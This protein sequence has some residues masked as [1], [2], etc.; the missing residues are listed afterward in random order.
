M[1]QPPQWCMHS[2]RRGIITGCCRRAQQAGVITSQANSSFV[3]NLRHMGFFFKMFD[4]NVVSLYTIII[5]IRS[6][7][8]QFPTVSKWC[9]QC[10]VQH[11]KSQKKK[12]EPTRPCCPQDRAVPHQR[13]NRNI[14]TNILIK[15]TPNECIQNQAIKIQISG[16]K[17]QN[18]PTPV[19]PLQ[20]HHSLT[21]YVSNHG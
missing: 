5:E 1:Y 6:G 15:I 10:L 17:K 9:T 16:R 7:R 2:L 3:W 21:C 20:W 18:K 19:S 4:L 11:Q 13:R 12:A 8:R 14:M